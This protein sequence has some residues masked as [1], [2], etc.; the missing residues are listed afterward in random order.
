MSSISIESLMNGAVCTSPDTPVRAVKDMLGD[1]EPISAV[2][3]VEEGR[4]VGLVM[5]LHLDRALS[6]QF[7]LAVYYSR[8]IAL[9]MDASPLAVGRGTAI[10]DAAQA[11][12]LREKHKI[13]D[14]LIVVDDD[15]R[16][17][18]IAPVPKILEALAT[19]EH[20]RTS[21]VISINERLMEEI[22]QRKAAD[23]ALRESQK[24]LESVI[25][26]FPHSIFWK[27][28]RGVYLGCNC[29][30]AAEAGREK[31]EDVMGKTDSDL[32]WKDGDADMFRSWDLSV[33]ESRAHQSLTLE[34]PAEGSEA[35]RYME[36]RK[37]PLYDSNG[38]I[39]GTLGS[40]EDVTE[41]LLADQA[42]EAN[43]AKS[44]FL[45][46]MS[47]EIRT[48]MNGVLGM[49][50]LLLGTEL[51]EHQRSLGETIFRSGEALLRVI[52]D[53]LDFSKIEAGKLEFDNV[54]FHLHNEVEELMELMA[55]HAHR[56]G[57]ELICQIESG[58]PWALKGDPGRLR[59]VLANLIGNAIKFT[60]QGEVLVRVQALEEERAA[61]NDSVLVE[62]E[63]RDTGIGISAEA[64]KRIFDAFA[65]S[66]MSTN[67][68]YGGTGLGL[69]ICRQL[70]EMMGGGIAVESAVGEGSAFRFRLR[71]GK[72]PEEAG[73]Q[74]AE[75]FMGK[76]PH[77]LIVDDN[78]TNRLVLHHQVTSWK[79]RDGMAE[80][81]EEA[82]AMLQ[83][84]VEKGDVYDVAIL[85]M[86]MPGMDGLELTRRIKAIPSLGG[87]K[88]IFLTS[89]G[90]YGE[91]ET[92]R[93]LGVSVYLTK[94]VR[95]SQLY[96]AMM[97]VL[98]VQV[99]R[100]APAVLPAPGKKGRALPDAPILLAED[101]PTNQQVCK[102]MLKRLGCKADVVS[103]GREALE[104]LSRTPYELVFMDCQMP[105][106]DG[107]E[108]T[109]QIRARE[110]AGAPRTVVV[111][112]TAHA[113]KGEREQ[114]LATGMDDYLS[115]P[116]SLDQLD[117]VLHRWLCKSADDGKEDMQSND[118]AGPVESDAMEDGVDAI[119]RKAL[120]DILMLQD[121]EDDDLLSEILT[122]YMEHSRELLGA[123][124]GAVE[125]DDGENVRKSAHSLKS[126]SANVGA[127][128]LAE[129]CKQMEVAACS[130]TNGSARELKMRIEAEH[131]KVERVLK[132]IVQSGLN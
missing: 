23:A 99:Q 79:M 35:P 92:A 31:P 108:A 61:D 25:E 76:T 85:D 110:E 59:Q 65:Q 132:G 10:E 42:M 112:L 52:N 111:A 63:V 73:A 107:Y 106:M 44:Q 97:N 119:D 90:Q 126:S 58:T 122:T 19:L 3:V 11:A 54:D 115:K 27:D 37:I 60:D 9:L 87:I 121:E 75:C 120:D 103:N 113:M 43:R 82:L 105:E 104:A 125:R 130:N 41:K 81:G 5:N 67:R 13:F 57:L 39:I 18:G 50:E 26:S 118:A 33:I 117:Y 45:A 109:R 4:P 114:C 102:A 21:E 101:N 48:P 86:M 1:D 66:D 36:I 29:K 80:G 127:M 128:N 89:V 15:G 34:Q 47:H 6:R 69:T 94:P 71:F 24:M 84:A 78:E 93:K 16:V 83:A 14:H 100:G 32:G 72:R 40:H 98:G 17:A 124:A 51:D 55:E 30:F 131:R 116:F 96:D 46:N 8:P 77:V 2:V 91:I 129:L 64:Q 123:L 28:R 12:M 70:C 49:A 74:A 22:D 88:L 95:Q 56:K 38:N 62:F 68:K 7:G 53:I 20:E